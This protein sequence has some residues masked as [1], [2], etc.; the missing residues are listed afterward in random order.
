APEFVQI[1]IAEA[2]A[3]PERALL[4]T[5]WDLR[6]AKLFLGSTRRNIEVAAIVPGHLDT[7]AA[8]SLQVFSGHP[9]LLQAGEVAEIGS[10]GRVLVFN[11]PAYDW[12]ASA[13]PPFVEKA[14]MIGL[15]QLH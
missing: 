7:V 8:A 4:A 12:G 15:S 3:A 10:T 6:G 2:A 11:V 5:R 1:A 13:N 14:S 9:C